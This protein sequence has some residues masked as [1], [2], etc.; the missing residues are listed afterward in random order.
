MSRRQH[1]GELLG[2]PVEASQLGLEVDPLV[3]LDIRLVDNC[4]RLRGGDRSK[5]E[6]RA[7]AVASD[8]L[9]PHALLEQE[10]KLLDVTKR[11][12]EIY[13]LGM[14]RRG[15]PQSFTDAVAPQASI[16]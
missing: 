14:F 13:Q 16:P 3:C 1:I 11:A 9:S 2:N 7:V 5:H 15:T 12:R 4:R 8:R 6:L 10:P